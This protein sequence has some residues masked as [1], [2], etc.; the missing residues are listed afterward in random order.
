MDRRLI[1]VWVLFLG[2]ALGLLGSF[3]FVN[4]A[5]GL[6]FP[7]FI[8][9]S[10]VVT[11]A[12][13]RATG[14]SINRRNLW[15]LL[16]LLFFAAMVAVR[17]DSLMITLNVLAVLAL[18]GLGLHYLTARESV[19]EARLSEQLAAVIL[20][21]LNALFGGFGELGL[22]LGWLRNRQ[23]RGK[24]AL[25]VGRGLLIAAPVLLVFTALLTS[26]DAV[27]A[28]YVDSIWQMFALNP[29]P[30]LMRYGFAAAVIGW[31]AVGALAYGVARLI[32]I[33]RT[34]PD[35]DVDTEPPPD[36]DA[37]ILNDALTQEAE[38]EKPKPAFRLG[39][40]EAGVV[41]GLVDLLFGLFVLV[42][43]AYFFGGEDFIT[44]RGLT[45]AEYARRGFF[46]MVAVSVMA[47]GLALWLD[48]VTARGTQREH[49]VFQALALVI[50]GLNSVMLLSASQRMFLYE[51]AFGFTHLR[52]FTHVAM[53]WIGV[54]FVFFLLAMF[55]VKRNVFSLGV[56]LVA[57]GYL[58]MLNLM[59]VDLY[60]AQNN[61]NRF[62]NGEA[63][64]LRFLTL[65]SAD[66]APEVLAFYDE[67]GD[68]ADVQEWAGQWL[69]RELNRLDIQRERY[70]GLLSANA[71]RDT[72]WA[73]LDARRDD[74]PAFDPWFFP[75]KG[76]YDYYNIYATPGSR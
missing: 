52:V 12:A 1:A 48:N 58:G 51:S 14:V 67:A 18:G 31:L 53:L 23:W 4:Q 46:E 24:S 64:D 55:R 16:P 6:S 50:V 15:P 69:A 74:L 60:I 9:L 3:F 38:A 63:L 32:P 43:L 20:S 39:M 34:Q 22:G 61:I 41:L 19:D 75:S 44:S 57:M 49:R 35:L 73:M 11:L 2:A 10:V 45:V 71:G 25:A 70:G 27:F 33:P 56:L 28:G 66:A 42:Q 17:A 62:Y 47:L 59:N 40:I 30:V 76:A 8:T 68:N 13:A 29:S 36:P 37:E 72:A 5:A 7:L 21:G 26:A 65:L 54:M